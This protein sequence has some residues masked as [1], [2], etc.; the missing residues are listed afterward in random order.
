MLLLLQR[1]CRSIPVDPLSQVLRVPPTAVHRHRLMHAPLVKYKGLWEADQLCSWTTTCQHHTNDTLLHTYESRERKRVNDMW[2]ESGEWWT[3]WTAQWTCRCSPL[4]RV[5]TNVWLDWTTERC[6]QSSIWENWIHATLQSWHVS[7]SV[8]L[9][10]KNLNINVICR[11]LTAAEY[12][13]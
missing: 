5:Y 1:R 3:S 7:R 2:S 6:S 4:G 11:I 8:F 10:H 9:S 13:W 12:W